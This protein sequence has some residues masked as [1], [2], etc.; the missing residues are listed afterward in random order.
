MRKADCEA[1][2][3]DEFGIIP[4][5]LKS[6]LEKLEK[7]NRLP[8]VLVTNPNGNNPTGTV[9]PMDRKHQIYKVGVLK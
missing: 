2:K 4:E 5:K 7:E 8:R 9:C 1:M 6:Q 3:T